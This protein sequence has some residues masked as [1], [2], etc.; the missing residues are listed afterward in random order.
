MI[1][2]AEAV[3]RGAR[4]RDESRGAHYKPEF[5][6]RDD[7]RFLKTTLARYDAAAGETTIEWGAVDL[8]NIQPRKRTYGR[9]EPR[10]DKEQPRPEPARGT[11]VPAGSGEGGAAGVV[12]GP[13]VAR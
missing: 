9:I 6:E 7:V 5:P 2:V 1:I 4:L 11:G 8:S 10:T 3:A 13:V 12:A